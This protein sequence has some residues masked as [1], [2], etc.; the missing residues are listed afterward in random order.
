MI[1]F[2]QIR[3]IFWHEFILIENY[4]E[5]LIQYVC[6]NTIRLANPWNVNDASGPTISLKCLYI[7]EQKEE[8]EIAKHYVAC[9]YFIRQDNA[10]DCIEAKKQERHPKKI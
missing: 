5:S 1:E 4:Y 9:S 6:G 7:V 2:S 10:T 3:D 8:W